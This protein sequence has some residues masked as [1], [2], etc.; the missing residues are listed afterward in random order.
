[1]DAPYHG[2]YVLFRGRVQLL[3]VNTLLLLCR[4]QELNSSNQAWWKT[5]L[6]FELTYPPKKRLLKCSSKQFIYNFYQQCINGCHL[7]KFR[8]YSE[9]NAIMNRISNKK[10]SRVG[11]KHMHLIFIPYHSSRKL[12]GGPV[13]SVY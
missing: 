6:T 13:A 4:C 11:H 10:L 7:F 2:T 9:A 8:D 3:G 5:P 12:A 1:M